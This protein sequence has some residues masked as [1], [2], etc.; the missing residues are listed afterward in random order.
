VKAIDRF[1]GA[2]RNVNPRLIL[3][4]VGMLTIGFTGIGAALPSNTGLVAHWSFDQSSG[5]T[6]TDNSGN[7]HTGTFSGSP[8]W[9]AGKINNDLTFSG[10]SYVKVGDIPQIDNVS[11][12]TLAAWVKKSSNGSNIEIG[13]YTA[14]NDIT[15]EAYGDGNVYFQ[16]SNG[17]DVHGVLSLSDTA[18]HHLALVFDG[19]QTGNANRLKAYVD[20]TQRTLSFTGTVPAKTTSNITPFNVGKVG[21]DYSTG[22]VD[23]MWLY[24]RALSQVEVQSLMQSGTDNT[25]PTAPANL[26]AAPASPSQ[27]NLTWSAATDDV[28]VAGYRIYRSGLPVGTTTGTTYQDTSLQA[29]LAYSYTV[30]AYD[31]AGNEGADSNNATATTPMPPTVTLTATPS[32]VAAGGSTTLTWNSANA[33]SC[34]AS[35]GWNGSEPTSGSQ[36]ISAIAAQT[37]YTLTC[38]GV[39]AQA[40]ASTTVTLLPLCNDGIDNDGD[41]LVDMADPGCSSTSDNDE[42]DPDTTA[43]TTTFT[44]P[45]NGSTVSGVINVN[46]TASDNVAVKQVVFTVDGTQRGATETSAPYGIVLDTSS[47]TNGTHTLRATATDTSGNTS[48]AEVT[49]DVEN[50]APPVDTTAPTVSLTAPTS[51]STV[52]GSSVAMAATATDNVG[53]V[54]VKFYAN[55][56]QVGSEV[57]SAP[58]GVTWNS[59]SVAN[60]SVQLSA[61]ARDAAG[62][63]NTSAVTVTV[64]NAL[65]SP[66][67]THVSSNGRY[68]QDQ[69]GQPILI[70]GDSPWS[71][72]TNLSPAQV[73]LW[74]AN[75]Q[76]HGVNTAIISLLGNTVNGGPHDNGATYDNILPFNNGNITS[77]NEAY[78]SRMDTFMTTLK[79]HGITVFLYASDGWVT[80]PGGVMSNKNAAESFTYGQMVAQRYA[81]YPNIVWMV[82]GDYNGYDNAINTH[83]KNIFDGIRATGDNRPRGIQ[84]NSETVST[85]V[86]FYEPIVNFNFAYTY[87]PT[88]QK[89]LRAYN[90]PL[91][92]RDPRPVIFNEG[93]YDGEDLYGG[94][95]TTNETLRRQQLW[96]LTSGAAGE[97]TGSEDWMFLSGWEN[98]LNTVWITQAQKNRD[99]FTSFSNWQLLVP[100]DASPIVTVGRGTKLTSDTSLDVRANDYVTATQTPD[101]SLSVVYVPTNTG[102]TDPRTITLDRTKLPTGF[103]ASW[104]DP[105]DATQSQAA[106]VDGAGQ[107]TTPGLHSDGTRDWLLV[108]RAQ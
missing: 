71:M 53:V 90:R 105:T 52:S 86:A 103:T 40:S 29:G 6:V 51:N 34:T 98:R 37:T 107:V 101:K 59:T 17:S 95:P 46:A 36:Q 91:G 99:W 94:L 42:A 67:V 65:T 7:G 50:Q 14:K 41:G 10:S 19:T 77:F 75:R 26:A 62:N 96:A 20:G 18:W 68:F 93:N 23:D 3:S 4:V 38:A 102:N 108:I 89:V 80:L 66:F 39:G 63:T 61:V 11:Q 13:K 8:T 72:F 58:Y 82:G 69:Y 48:F 24:A 97:F 44:N 35:G 2:I 64:S 32:A 79:N 49:I 15:I 104:V 54:G 76:S 28:G 88:Y 56:T 12:V 27:I 5:T 16:V 84:L 31:A 22:Q 45:A 47:L 100:D 92:V 25:P 81:S 30:R 83:F 33:S 43:P 57:T 21:S 1:A 74:A 87:A 55:G 106:I 73:E 78:W 60:G 9:T 70:K 85:D